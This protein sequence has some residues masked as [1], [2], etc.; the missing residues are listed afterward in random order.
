LFNLH[1][2]RLDKIYANDADVEKETVLT[3]CACSTFA[4]LCVSNKHGGATPELPIEAPRVPPRYS[5]A[6]GLGVVGHRLIEASQ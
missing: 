5:A 2:Y 6:M 3:V 1:H 4:N